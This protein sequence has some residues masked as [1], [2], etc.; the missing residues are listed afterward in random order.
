[1]KCVSVWVKEKLS[2]LFCLLN[3]IVVELWSICYWPIYLWALYASAFFFHFAFLQLSSAH[4]FRSLCLLW[5]VSATFLLPLCLIS[6]FSC[7]L[8]CCP[9]WEFCCCVCLLFCSHQVCCF[10]SVKSA[11]DVHIIPYN[12]PVI[13]H[14]PAA[15]VE[16]WDLTQQVAYLWYHIHWYKQRKV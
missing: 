16:T 10:T 2:S 14:G 13:N 12:T 9:S 15:K 8:Y 3:V 7:I 4:L 6:L 1:M 5:S 11:A